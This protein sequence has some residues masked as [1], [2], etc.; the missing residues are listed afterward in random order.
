[1][2][3]QEVCGNKLGGLLTPELQFGV[4]ILVD[5]MGR[6]MLRTRMKPGQVSFTKRA[7]PDRLQGHI[8]LGCNYDLGL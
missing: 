6:T 4:S 7:N 1:M 2:I 3:T 8:R 5:S